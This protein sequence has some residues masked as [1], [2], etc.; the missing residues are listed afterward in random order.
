MDPVVQQLV[1]KLQKA[2]GDRLVSVVLYGSAAAGDRQKG[3]SDY[4]VLCVLRRV[5][6]QE[7][8]DGEAVFRWWRERGSPSPLLLGEQ[9]L[10]ASTDCFVIEFHDMKRQH[11]LLAGK[12]VIS[13][14]AV[15]GRYYRSQVEHDLRAKVLRL[16]QKAS[17]MLSD[18][19]LLLRLLL[20]SVS[21]FCVLFRHAL[22][23]H[24]ADGP[25]TKRETIARASQQFAFDPQPFEKL[26][27]VREGK[28]KARDVDPAALLGS[29]LEAISV[30]IAAVDGLET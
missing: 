16:R 3:F 13:N 24:G 2:Y 10:A 22:I 5:T 4:N 23:L 12:D 20:D 29:Y 1:E 15:D 17:G 21:T 11:Q 27:A 28:L 25:A 6:P 8:S 14:L 7:L 30:V 19:G 9:E 26:L 18:S